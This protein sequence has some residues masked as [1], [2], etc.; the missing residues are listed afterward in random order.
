MKKV[1]LYAITNMYEIYSILVICDFI[2]ALDSIMD[3]RGFISL[4]VCLG[5]EYA[6]FLPMYVRFDTQYLYY[7]LICND[8]YYINVIKKRLKKRKFVYACK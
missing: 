6:L 4:S 5:L 7:A 1:N 8:D 3:N 2:N